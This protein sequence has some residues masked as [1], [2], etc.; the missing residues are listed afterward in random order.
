M[1]KPLDAYGDNFP[2]SEGWFW[3][4]RVPWRHAQV[5][6][7]VKPWWRPVTWWTLVMLL[8][9]LLLLLAAH[10]GFSDD[11]AAQLVIRFHDGALIYPDGVLRALSHEVTFHSASLRRLNARFGL[12][13][14]ERVVSRTRSTHGTFKLLFASTSGLAEALAAYRHDP[15]VISVEP[16][17]L[18]DGEADRK[19]QTSHPFFDSRDA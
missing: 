17:I 8:M 1:N 16:A 19:G 13:A 11:G 15:Q 14:V 4:P 2:V 12:I 6:P 18:K 5:T 10:E 3:D 9:G 7:T